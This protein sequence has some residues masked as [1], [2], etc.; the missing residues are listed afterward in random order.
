MH[1]VNI[2][3]KHLSLVLSLFLLTLFTASLLEGV[4]GI[5]VQ[6]RRY[7]LPLSVGERALQIVKH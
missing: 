4:S 2:R 3:N 1:K 5:N 7:G 6:T